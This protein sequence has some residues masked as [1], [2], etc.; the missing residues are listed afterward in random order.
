MSDS[1]IEIFKIFRISSS[2]NIH[3]FAV[4]PHISFNLFFSPFLPFFSNIYYLAINY[5]ICYSQ[6]DD[7]LINSSMI[8]FYVFFARTLPGIEHVFYT[9]LLNEQMN[10]HLQ[11]YMQILDIFNFYYHLV[12]KSSA[13]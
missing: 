4:F 11:K 6:L 1:F 12:S 13:C 3:N 7:K 9:Y 2:N 10:V 5:I 8:L